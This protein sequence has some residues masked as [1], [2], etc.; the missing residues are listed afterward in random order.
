M[1]LYKNLDGTSTGNF[2]INGPTSVQLYQDLM[3]GRDLISLRNKDNTKYAPLRA[4][5]IIGTVTEYSTPGKDLL[6]V[7]TQKDVHSYMVYITGGF[8]GA[9]PGTMT[10]DCYYFCHTSGGSYT[11]GNVYYYNGSSLELVPTNYI[12]FLV[13]DTAITGTISLEA[14]WLYAWTGSAWEQKCT[15]SPANNG[16]IYIKV[17]IGTSS[18]YTS[19]AKIPTGC[20]VTDVIADITT[21]Y[22]SSSLATVEVKCGS[23]TLMDIDNNYAEEVNQYST[24]DINA[25]STAAVVTVNVAGTPTA[26]AGTVY[27]GFVTPQV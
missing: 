14:D 22:V 9:S 7:A 15:M 12:R 24:E 17:L 21:A 6:S 8:N 18:S 10:N 19:T 13:S 5:D 26:G 1:G 3:N 2:H 20:I 23:I 4:L 25:I 11:A 27:V 16:K